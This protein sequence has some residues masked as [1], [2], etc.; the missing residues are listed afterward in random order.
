M[1]PFLFGQPVDSFPNSY[2]HLMFLF[3][4]KL[5][6]RNSESLFLKF[7]VSLLVKMSVTSNSDVSVIAP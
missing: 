3:T 4:L 5:Y 7:A 2:F 6:S 1:C